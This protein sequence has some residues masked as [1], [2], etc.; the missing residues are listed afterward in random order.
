[1]HHLQQKILIFIEMLIMIKK[2][3]MEIRYQER[4]ILDLW[5]C[6]DHMVMKI[7]ILKNVLNKIKSSKSSKLLP[8]NQIVKLMML[9]MILI[10]IH[11]YPIS[12]VN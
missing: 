4:I 12:K 10:S 5:V 1:M 7:S 8:V 3:K 2:D 6:L 11:L 9:N